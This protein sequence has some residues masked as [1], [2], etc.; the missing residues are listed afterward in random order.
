MHFYVTMYKN[1]TNHNFF[2][3]NNFK[4]CSGEIDCKRGKKICSIFMPFLSVFRR[5]TK[6]SLKKVRKFSKILPF[7]ANFWPKLV[8]FFQICRISPIFGIWRW[9]K[10]AKS[11]SPSRPSI[12]P[13]WRYFARYANT[14]NFKIK[15]TEH[16]P[17]KLRILESAKNDLNLKTL[18]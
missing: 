2:L 14:E 18:C 13:I 4:I 7:Y 12:S 16:I 10:L 1:F 8:N 3:K 9:A 15:I 11:L 6:I 5:V 17:Y